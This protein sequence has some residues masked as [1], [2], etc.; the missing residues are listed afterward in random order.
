MKGYSRRN[1]T[2][3]LAVLLAACMLPG[4]R[5]AAQTG[6]ASVVLKA[7]GSESDILKTTGVKGGV[8]VLLGCDDP[9]LA[10]ALRASDSFLVHGLDTDPATVEKARRH[11]ASSGL[12]GDIAIQ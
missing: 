1:G 2:W 4:G 5:A 7:S 8:V 6:L 10:V 12:Y 3:A 9:K 11:V